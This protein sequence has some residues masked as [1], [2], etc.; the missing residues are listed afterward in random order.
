MRMIGAL[1]MVAALAACGSGATPVATI[2]SPTT[3]PTTGEPGPPSTTATADPTTTVASPPSTTATQTTS[4]PTTVPQATGAHCVLPLQ[5]RWQRGPPGPLP[6]SGASHSPGN[7]RGGSG[8]NRGTTGR[9]RTERGISRDRHR[10]PRDHPPSRGEHRGRDGHRRFDPRFRVG[11]GY[12]IDDRTAGAAG[13]HR[14]P[15]PHGGR[16]RVAPRRRAGR[17]VLRRGDRHRRPAHPRGLPR[18]RAPDHGR[19]TGVGR[20][21]G[22]PGPDRRNRRSLR[23]SVPGA[24]TSM[25]RARS[26]TRISP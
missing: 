7:D 26:S 22:E 8:R 9:P 20:D 14:D 2:T 5:P 6:H 23:G 16:R 19:N 3:G 25:P 1:V 12:D 13:L 11:R 4:P 18:L 17:G 10:G 21:A 24:A 15:V